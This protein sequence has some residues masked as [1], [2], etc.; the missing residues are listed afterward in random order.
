MDF[1]FHRDEFFEGLKAV[2]LPY[3]VAESNIDEVWQSVSKEI[4][5]IETYLEKPSKDMLLI[6]KIIKDIKEK[7]K[8]EKVG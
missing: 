5:D 6:D 1:G 3:G 4:K 8:E 2:L 7:K